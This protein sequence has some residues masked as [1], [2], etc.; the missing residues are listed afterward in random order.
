MKGLRH[1]LG[2]QQRWNVTIHTF[3]SDCV[4][5]LSKHLACPIYEDLRGPKTGQRHKPLVSRKA[6]E[7]KNLEKLFGSSARSGGHYFCCLFDEIFKNQIVLELYDTNQIS[8][9]IILT[10][11]FYLAH[12]LELVTTPCLSFL[13]NRNGCIKITFT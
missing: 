2:R 6:K 11:T 12:S 5:G 7:R 3:S 10:L 8:W 9:A 4:G 1:V 13:T